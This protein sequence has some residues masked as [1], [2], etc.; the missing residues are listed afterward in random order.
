MVTKRVDFC[1]DFSW[2][3]NSL[4]P[5]EEDDLQRLQHR[6]CP[7]VKIG[8]RAECPRFNATP[9]P[10]ITRLLIEKRIISWAALSA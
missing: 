1:R 8:G 2:P 3:M 7:V 10:Y 9:S 5:S 4:S 6:N